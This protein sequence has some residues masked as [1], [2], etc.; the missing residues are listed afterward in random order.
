MVKN[1]GGTVH[2]GP[3]DVPGGDLIIVASDP[4]GTMFGVVGPG[5]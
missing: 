3:M 4:H 2:A 1:G 5:Q